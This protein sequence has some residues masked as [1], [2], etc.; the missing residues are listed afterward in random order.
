MARN[1]S[2]SIC[3]PCQRSMERRGDYGFNFGQERTEG[4]QMET[5]RIWL[6]ENAQGRFIRT[7]YLSEFSASACLKQND[8][9]HHPANCPHK[10]VEFAGRARGRTPKERGEMR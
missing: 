8:R 9:I 5:Q 1:A 4:E 6:I 7:V 10:I 2:S 3:K